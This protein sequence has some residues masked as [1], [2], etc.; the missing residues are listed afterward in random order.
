MASRQVS[1]TAPTTARPRVAKR[2]PKSSSRNPVL[3]RAGG[4][5]GRSHPLTLPPKQWELRVAARTAR[6]V[7]THGRDIANDIIAAAWDLVGKYEILDFTVKQVARRADVALQTLYRYFG[8]KDELLLAMF[9]ES[10]YEATVLLD[11]PLEQPVERLKHIVT[12][13]ILSRYDA[14]NQRIVRWRGRERQRLLETFP[15]AVEAVYEPYR[16]LIADAIV[17]LC[18]IGEA[19]S[20]DPDLDASLILHFVQ[21]MAHAVHGGGFNE[22][23]EIVADHVWRMCWAG[24]GADPGARPSRRRPRG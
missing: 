20:D 19:R 5:G 13:P 23:P 12:T 9:E 24:I 11:A 1:Q 3:T 7:D 4:A 18:E 21:T 22:S 14:R 15:D 6:A 2:L 17:A 10:M 8:S 16:V